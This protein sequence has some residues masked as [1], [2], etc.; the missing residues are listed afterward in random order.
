MAASLFASEAT[1]K[2]H[3]HSVSDKLEHRARLQRVSFAHNAVY[4]VPEL[5]RQR[6]PT[7]P[8]TAPGPG[9]REAE[10]SRPRASRSCSGHGPPP[11]VNSVSGS[12]PGLESSL[13]VGCRAA[14]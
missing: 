13:T 6:L 2:S 10:H 5:D 7:A 4:W 14:R 11:C 3:L 9:G 1:I 8:G 12:P